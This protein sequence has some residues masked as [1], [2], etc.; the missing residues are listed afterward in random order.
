MY[1]SFDIYVNAPQNE[2]Q[3]VKTYLLT[4]APNEDLSQPQGLIQRGFVGFGRTPIWLKTS[5]PEILNDHFLIPCLP[6]NEAQHEKKCL[7]TCAPKGDSNQPAHSCSLIRD[8]VVC[9]KKLCIIGYPKC[10]HWRFWSDCV[11][12]Q[13]DLNLLLAYVRRYIFWRCNFNIWIFIFSLIHLNFQ[14]VLVTTWFNITVQ[15]LIKLYL[16]DHFDLDLDCL[17]SLVCLDV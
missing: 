17:L 1:F 11:K 12:V 5:I 3:C 13:V 10:A 16:G 6:F 9:M 2:G 7:L 4:W 14:Q 8:F 15:S